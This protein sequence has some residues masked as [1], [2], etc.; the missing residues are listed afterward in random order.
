VYYVS[1][2]FRTRRANG[3][4]ED[5]FRSE[6]GVPRSIKRDTPMSLRARAVAVAA[7]QASDAATA[8]GSASLGVFLGH[9]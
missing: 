2:G 7:A 3:R 9:L 8:S 5:L 4:T 1:I 6:A